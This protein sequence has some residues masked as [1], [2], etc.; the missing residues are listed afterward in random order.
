MRIHKPNLAHSDQFLHG[1]MPIHKVMRPAR[2]IR[3]SGFVNIDSHVVV[4]RR[5]D[6]LEMHRPVVGFAAQAIRGRR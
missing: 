5:E 2:E 3:H 4:K 1:L 6:L